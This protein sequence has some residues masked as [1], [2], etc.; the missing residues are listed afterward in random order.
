MTSRDGDAEPL[1][2]RAR[3]GCERLSSFP[4]LIEGGWRK[5]SAAS[6]SRTRHI[7]TAIEMKSVI[8]N[9]FVPMNAAA[10][11]AHNN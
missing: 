8:G 9:R 3:E 11:S 5:R 2:R 7:A 4:A 6:V 10:F 1:R